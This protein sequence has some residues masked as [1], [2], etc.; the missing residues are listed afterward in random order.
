MST[1]LVKEEAPV[2]PATRDIYPESDASPTQ[3]SI[4]SSQ[5][6]YTSFFKRWKP[7]IAASFPFPPFS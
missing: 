5:Q 1:E 3:M 7:K 2:L 4:S 6:L